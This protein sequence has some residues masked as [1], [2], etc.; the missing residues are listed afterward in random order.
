M[1]TVHVGNQLE[2]RRIEELKRLIDSEEYIS[3][4]IH[5]IAHIISEELLAAP[6]RGDPHERKQPRRQ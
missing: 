4:A 5:R 6:Y 1:I 2:P 3:G